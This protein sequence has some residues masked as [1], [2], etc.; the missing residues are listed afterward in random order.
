[1]L[2]KV[3]SLARA[4]ALV[5]AVVAAFVA[6]PAQV[7][8][9]LLVLGIIAGL[10]YGADDFARLA[11]TVLALP[12]IGAALGLIPTIGMQLT[13]VA[14]NTALAVAGALATRMAIRLYEV[15]VGDL[16]GLAG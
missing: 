10:N 7:P 12:V 6:I 13:A 9:I 15:V 2:N 11:L 8:L 4:V 1:M 14:A 5:L 16:K 3:A